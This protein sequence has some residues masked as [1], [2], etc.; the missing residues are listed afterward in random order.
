MTQKFDLY[1]H[2]FVSQ[3]G[4]NL[5]PPAPGNARLNYSVMI[6]ETPCL[7]TVSDSQLLCDSPDLTGEQ[8]VMVSFP[9][10]WHF[11]SCIINNLIHNKP[12]LSVHWLRLTTLHLSLHTSANER[13]GKWKAGQKC[14]MFALRGLCVHYAPYLINLVINRWRVR[15]RFYLTLKKKA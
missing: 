11:P 2:V 8:R 3:Q 1:F 15:G 7:L 13:G 10:L 5:I 12:R 9:P 4:K 6:G 14:W